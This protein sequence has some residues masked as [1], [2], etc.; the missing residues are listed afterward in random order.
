M[1][2]RTGFF[3]SDGRQEPGESQTGPTWHETRNVTVA[4]LVMWIMPNSLQFI[5][6]HDETLHFYIQHAASSTG[7]S[8]QL[9]SVFSYNNGSVAAHQNASVCC[10]V[11]WLGVGILQ[12]NIQVQFQCPAVQCLTFTA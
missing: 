8:F 9:P 2:P 4:T 10:N 11:I 7:K 6:L 1:P 5:K 12:S 3:E